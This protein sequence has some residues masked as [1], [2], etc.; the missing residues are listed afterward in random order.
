ML[1]RL[2]L[3]PV[4]ALLFT[5]ISVAQAQTSESAAVTFKHLDE[6]LQANP[7]DFETAFDASSDGNELYRGKGHFLIQ[8]PND[9]RAEITLGHNTYLI[10]SDGTVLT[11]YDE[12]QHKYSQTAAPP[13]LAAAFGFFTGEIGIDS[14]VLNF[15]DIVDNVV[16]AS[17][18][19]KASTAGSDTIDGKACDKFA[20]ADASGDNTWQVW[21]EKGDKPLLCK[22]VYHSVDG[23]EQTNSFSWKTSPAFAAD[24]FK[25]SP[26]AGSAKVD[27]GDLNLAS[28]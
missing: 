7:L 12:Q 11:I 1:N 14:Q 10:I 21:L 3:Y 4:L 15:M 22:L 27:I 8:R 26:P 17:D 28:P 19:T 16:S 18:G 2:L 6:Y 23:P 20:V 25:F 13:S 24:T 5:G 9:L